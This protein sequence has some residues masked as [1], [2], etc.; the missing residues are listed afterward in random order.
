ME[1]KQVILPQF[2]VNDF[3]LNSQEKSELWYKITFSLMIL[4]YAN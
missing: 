2:H 4:F 1:K 3:N